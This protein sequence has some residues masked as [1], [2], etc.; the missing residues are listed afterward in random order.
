[1]GLGGGIWFFFFPYIVAAI[2]C[3]GSYARVTYFKSGTWATPV[4]DMQVRNGGVNGEG[5]CAPVQTKWSTDPLS[6]E[7]ENGFGQDALG[8]LMIQAE[9]AS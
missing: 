6:P 7:E 9:S 3:F 4:D 1:M 5:R 2:A 8:T